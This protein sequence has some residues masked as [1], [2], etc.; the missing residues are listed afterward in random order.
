MTELLKIS[1]GK[2]GGSLLTTTFVFKVGLRECL[3]GFLL[4]LFFF[5]SSG[6][7][8]V[9]V[10]VVVE[11]AASFDFD[12]G[13]GEAETGVEGPVEFAT[14][15]DIVCTR[16]RTRKKGKKK[17]KVSNG[18]FSMEKGG[19]KHEGLKASIFIIINVEMDEEDTWIRLLSW[20]R[21]RPIRRHLP[22]L[23]LLSV[24]ALVWVVLWAP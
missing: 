5:F 17:K 23:H 6:F 7:F 13:F 10:V 16:T 18:N 15:A 2:L 22:A 20:A 14:E 3:F 1:S 11:A 12:D 4:A 21:Y 19:S 9:V 8:V 24:L